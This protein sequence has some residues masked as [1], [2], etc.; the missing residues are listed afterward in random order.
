MIVQSCI[1]LKTAASAICGNSSPSIAQKK[2]G[3][4]AK[5]YLDI[6]SQKCGSSWRAALG[7]EEVQES[8]V[9]TSGGD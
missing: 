7:L 5:F 2:N 9:L 4:C 8:L 3:G 6:V 1:L